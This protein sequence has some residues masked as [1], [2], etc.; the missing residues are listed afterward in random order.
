MTLSPLLTALLVLPPLLIAV[1]LHEI[2]HGLAAE[3]LGDPTARVLGRIS[4][5]P[6]VH[7]DP[8]LT[9]LVPG[10]L[11]FFNSPFV[12]GGAK[13]VP[14]N[15]VY[16][17]NPRRDMLWVALAG[18]VMNIFIACISIIVFVLI[19]DITVNGLVFS[20]LKLLFL[21]WSSHSVAI[22]IVLAV[23]N[24]IPI[25]PL[26]GGRIAVGL[27]PLSLAKVMMRIEPM[28]IFLVLILLYTGAFEVIL[29]PVL[30]LLEEL[31]K[32][33]LLLF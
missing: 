32:R 28:G 30:L 7:I 27:L 31:G 6:I 1:I 17:K 19:R 13:P 18:P 26:D 25:P 33:G 9:I 4:L 20:F 12:F 8:V 16:F 24:L 10:L 23:F 15:P 3:R 11:L 5:N 21:A 29:S 2:A 14:V 22:N